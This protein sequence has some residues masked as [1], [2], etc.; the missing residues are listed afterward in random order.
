MTDL[1]YRAFLEPEEE[2]GYHAYIPTLPGVHTFAATR[3]EALLN[4]Q[5]A[6][7]AYIEDMLEQGEQPPAERQE[8]EIT[9]TA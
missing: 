4:V 2:G 3:D 5:E 7:A 1:R 9:V 6:A 8:A